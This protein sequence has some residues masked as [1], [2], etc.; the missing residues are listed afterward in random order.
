M[1]TAPVIRL[2]ELGKTYVVSEREPGIRAAL[3]SLVH[4]RKNKV[5]AVDGISFDVAPG[6]IVGFLGPNG[7]GKTTTL[8]MLSGLLHPTSGEV[9]V[10][11]HV[12]WK[13]EKAF[14]RRITLVMG[15]RNQLVWDI[16]AADTFELNRAIYRIPAAEYRA[17]LDELV[18]LLDLEPLLAKPVRNL[19]LGER[20]KCEIAAALLHRPGVVFL[21]EPTIGLDVT[22]QRRIRTFI[23]EYSRRSGATVLLTSHYMA[24]VE[25]LC[26]RVVVIHQG[27][28]LFDGELAGLVQR[29]TSHK[30]IV[31]QL[32]D[33]GA[34]LSAYGEVL[35]CEDGRVTLRIPKA[36][37]ARV[38]GRLLADQSVIDLTVA[39]PA[40]EE[41]IER[42]FA[43]EKM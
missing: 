26:K 21:D 43:Q 13:R 7:A 35:S 29:F 14:L 6:E 20:M 15:Q 39:D 4:R 38:T 24:D 22:M 12:P 36:E 11:S 33:C 42:V 8:K 31:V 37:T 2:R 23:A 18:A 1:E 32:K 34:D 17:T 25:A 9:Y 27:K 30:T 5:R 3:A 41:V 16:P 10:L 28:L 19:S 40:I